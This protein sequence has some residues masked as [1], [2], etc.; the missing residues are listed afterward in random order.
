[1]EPPTLKEQG[2]VPKRY[3]VAI[4]AFLGM[5]SHFVL[6]VNMNITIVAMVTNSNNTITPAQ[7][8]CK[9]DDDYD[10]NND[11]DGEFE[12]DEWTQSLITSAYSIGSI[13]TQVLGGRVAE[14]VG[15]RRV[16]GG[17]LLAASCSTLFIP[18]AARASSGALVAVRVIMG[19]AL[20][21]TYP[22][23]HALLATW[24]PPLERS[25]LSAII[26]AGA[27][28]GT[29]VAFPLSAAIIDWQGWEAVF[30]IQGCMA[31]VWCLAW[32]L[33]VSDTPYKDTRITQVERDYIVTSLGDSKNKK[34]LPV[35]LR[36]ALTSLPFWAILVAG[37]GNNW[38]FC[39]LLTDLPLYT[40]NMLHKDIKS[41]AVLSGLPYLGMWIFSLVVSVTG[42]TLR[43]KGILSTQ[44]LRKVA[45]TIGHLGPAVCL[46]C[47]SFV[48]CDRSATIALFVI[49]LTLQGGI[50]TGYVVN[51][52]DIAPNF[53]G[54]LYGITN[55]AATVPAILAPMAVGVL[56]NNQQTFGQWRKVF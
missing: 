37:V 12:W 5:V 40:K 22:S 49:A 15:A 16:L 39:T 14:L 48:E 7:N 28:A 50:Y 30:Y 9:F 2:Y 13:W 32:F 43:Q 10:T 6:R 33:I 52:M 21:V 45:N 56:T 35:P 46:V 26:Y 54:T 42:D 29:I 36:S 55:T 17:A 51:H 8:I 38:G 4:M 25:I 23:T 34:A 44:T 31:L 27:Q 19:L 1:M 41:N 20:G 3:I 47:L 24:A 53:A 18:L 11:Y